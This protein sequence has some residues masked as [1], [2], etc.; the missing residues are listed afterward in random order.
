MTTF[1]I[2]QVG[3]LLILAQL[4]ISSHKAQNA[5]AAARDAYVERLKKYER[6]HGAVG[7][8][9]PRDERCAS[10]IAYTA[11]E[12]AALMASRRAAYNIKRRLSN[13]CRKVAP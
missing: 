3:Q 1:N 11:D 6:K 2:N 13:A 9:D 5:V 10:A 12:Y 4:S 8:I 7:R